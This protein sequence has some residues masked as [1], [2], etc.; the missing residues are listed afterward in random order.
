MKPWSSG[1]MLSSFRE[2][3][4]LMLPPKF[5]DAK[6][7]RM[8]GREPLVLKVAVNEETLEIR[9]GRVP[10]CA[11]AAVEAEAARAV[12]AQGG[13]ELHEP[14]RAR[15]EY[16]LFLQFAPLPRPGPMHVP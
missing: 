2:T 12:A 4:A 13:E 5:P 8:S 16:R 15:A 7:S 11:E 1:E 10:V 14:G 9:D 6:S 3:P